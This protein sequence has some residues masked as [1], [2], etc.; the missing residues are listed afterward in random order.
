MQV[1]FWGTRGSIPTPGPGTAHYGGNTSCVEVRT[2]DGNIF[3]LDCGTGIRELG[4]S[5]LEDATR[6]PR[7]HILIGHTHWDHIQGFPFFTPV[8]IPGTEINIYAPL[9]FQR[10]LE[11]A[12]S[13]QMQY[14]YFPV[15]LQ[16]LASRIHYT[17]LD[18]GF[19]R[20]G[21]C[22]VETQYLNHTAPTI[23]YRLTEGPTS[24]AYVTDHEPY[25]KSTG[26]DFHQPFQHPGDQRH[27]DFIR[28]ADLLIH[29]AQYSD[30]EYKAKVGWGHSP[31][32]YVGAVAVAAGVGRI[33]LT[34]HDPTHNDTWVKDAETQLRET[35]AKENPELEVFAAAEG[36]ELVVEGAGANHDVVGDSALERRSI[37][38][39]R[40]LLISPD[41]SDFA[42]MERTLVDDGLI[43]M[44]AS[45]SAVALKRADEFTPSLV[46]IDEKSI[47]GYAALTSELR[48]RTGRPDLPVILL[49]HTG[50]VDD[51]RLLSENATD[52]LERPFSHPMLRTRVRAWISRTSTT[53]ALN[54]GARSIRSDE[55]EIDGE[56]VETVPGSGRP[57]EPNLNDADALA[58]SVLFRDLEPDQL[59]KLLSNASE[60]IFPSG[61]PI[62]R[63]GEPGTSA[64]V[65]MSGKVRI[66]ESIPEGPADMFLGELGVGE[67]FGEIGF[68]R[69]TPRSAT[70]ATLE[71]TRCLVFPQHE[72][73]AS[74]EASPALCL[75]LLRVLAGRVAAADRLLARYAPDPL[76]GLPGRRAFKDLY[77]RVAPG[78]RRR[79]SGV[80]LLLIDIDNLKGINDELGYGLGD[81]VLK[82]TAGALLESSRSTD[83]IARVGA[84]EFAV[85]LIDTDTSYCDHITGRVNAH[86]AE[87]TR[88][89][90]LHGVIRYDVGIAANERAPEDLDALLH[91]AD[92]ELHKSKRKK[93]TG[94]AG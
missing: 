70:V 25:W 65:I 21:D 67:I 73:L 8:F 36:M 87:L 76:T 18:E 89:R 49:T 83:L 54:P 48:L 42:V 43:L 72:F 66:M 22:L 86:L 78:T 94:Q 47:P 19:F 4:L 82:A 29:D 44:T 5:L 33:A 75:S 12:M 64:F 3:V 14:S 84:D 2:D 69:D 30:E 35:L 58:Q 23:G 52:Y 6:P 71:R 34:H 38:G 45:T 7:I 88:Q 61:Y 60:Q 28:N 32:G 16:D 93:A 20:I 56:A 31:I 46:I 1:R 10:S 63:E 68:L 15:K 40:I 27:I 24:V 80:I 85:L 41:E 9:G 55:A 90:G 11:D 79:G 17:E 59:A 13:G 57:A 39:Q 37:V 26:T 51:A 50:E 74:L 62:L 92:D 81:D 77:N 91:L 53:K